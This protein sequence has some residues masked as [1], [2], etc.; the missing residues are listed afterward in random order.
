MNLEYLYKLLKPE[1]QDQY[2]INLNKAIL[3]KERPLFSLKFF[4]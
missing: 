2:K 4:I 1:Q 3:S